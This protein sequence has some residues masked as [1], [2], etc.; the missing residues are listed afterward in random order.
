MNATYTPLY[1]LLALL[2]VFSAL[3]SASETALFGV[4]HGQR[5]SLKRTNPRLSRILESLL[6]RP[7]E[8]LM[9]VLLLNMTVNVSYF[10]VTSIL[11]IRAESSL[12]RVVISL[13]SLTAIILIGEVFAKLFASSATVLFLRV[14][15]PMHLLIRKPIVPLL[16]FLDVWVIAPLARLLAPIKSRQSVQTVSPEQMGT[17]IHLSAHDGVIDIGEQELLT[18]IVSIGNMRVEQIMTPRVDLDWV[19][20]DTTHE[21]II[22]L[23][24]NRKRTM[25]LVCEHGMDQGV[26]GIVRVRK[27]LE[28]ESIQSA[29]SD[30]FYIPEQSRLDMLMEQLRK[31]GRS[32]AVCVDEHGGVSGVVT[33]ADV[34][35]ELIDGVVDP[36]EDLANEIELIGVGKWVVPGRLSIREWAV[37]MSDPSMIAHTKHI[38]TLGGLIMVL[39]DR[40]PEMG[41]QANIGDIK[42]TVVSM[43]ERS[44]D[45]VEVE[46]VSS[47]EQSLSDAD[48][49]IDRSSDDDSG[50]DS[51]RGS[52]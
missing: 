12:A 30:V 16:R 10:I 49:S 32:I 1:I 38:N 2:L 45:R 8:L 44:I 34:M 9:Q 3:A 37:M 36:Q 52:S 40:I 41:D 47:Q 26:S 27:V 51:D 24:R 39:L 28:G 19:T 43:N 5:A 18:S 31:G 13:V 22:E 35:K 33:L 29:M 20:L 11:T 50:N 15:A 48:E 14:A 17:L 23:C 46:I 21:E 25:L 6:A 42:L 4:S 7:R